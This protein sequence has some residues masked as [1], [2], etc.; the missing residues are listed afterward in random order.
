MTEECIICLGD[1]TNPAR[2][3]RCQHIFCYKCLKNWIDTIVTTRAD[4][5]P[6]CP[7]CR[8]NIDRANS[9]NPKAVKTSN[10]GQTFWPL[11]SNQTEI[12][13]QNRE[14]RNGTV[15]T[16]PPRDFERQL[17]NR[18][19]YPNLNEDTEWWHRRREL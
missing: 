4:V 1:L 10:Q 19:A 3:N 15:F 7:T 6:S 5:K 18:H 12:V 2:I 17:P 14:K 11:E 16:I 8:Q 9:V 13:K